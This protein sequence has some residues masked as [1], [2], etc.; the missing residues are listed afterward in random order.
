MDGIEKIYPS[1][2]GQGMIEPMPIRKRLEYQKQRFESQLADV[3]DAIEALDANPEILK[4]LEAVQK[5]SHF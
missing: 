4:A 3:I 5:V 1:T 2:H